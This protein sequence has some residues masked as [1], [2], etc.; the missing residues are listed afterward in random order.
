M[1]IET[2]YDIKQQVWVMLRIATD[3]IMVQ[4]E[5]DCR[6]IHAITRRVD[7]QTIYHLEKY[8][9]QFRCDYFEYE[10]FPTEEALL[11]ADPCSS[12]DLLLRENYRTPPFA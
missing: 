2:K 4:K 12:F 6:A 10:V 9:G 8:R 1:T 3:N 5:T 11:E 7:G